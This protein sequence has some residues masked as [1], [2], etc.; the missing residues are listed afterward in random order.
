VAAGQRKNRPSRRSVVL[1]AALLE[2]AD[3]GYAQ[4]TL[5]AVASRAR[6]TVTA[7]YYHFDSKLALL[8]ELVE[9]IAGQMLAAL[10]TDLNE[11]DGTGDALMA[12]FDAFARWVEEHEEEARLF[13]LRA[14]GVSPEVEQ[15]RRS[16][17]T[18]V[19]LMASDHVRV[20]RPDLDLLTSRVV[21]LAVPT[22]LEEYASLR[23]AGPISTPRLRDV[24]A[25]VRHLGGRL[26]T[27]DAG[28]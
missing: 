3:N 23:L 21:G 14:P 17:T 6:I 18:R 9:R 24:R 7:V 11:Q 10:P 27:L 4:T 2:I 25:A 5:A 1:D 22:T 13:F 26:D 16:W 8:V 12:I 28:V 19:A 15:L 20:V